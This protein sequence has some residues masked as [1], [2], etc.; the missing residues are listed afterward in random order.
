MNGNVSTPLRG[1]I[2]SLFGPFEAPLALFVVLVGVALGAAINPYCTIFVAIGLPAVLAVCSEKRLKYGLLALAVYTAFEAFLLNFVPGDFYFY[3][4]FGHYACLGACFLV[5]L[6]RRL[7]EGRPLWV[8]TPIDVPMALFL[9]VSLISFLI[10]RQTSIPPIAA[11][12]AFQPFLRFIV[13]VFY[14]LMFIDFDK[15]D[16]LR[17]TKVLLAVVLVEGCVGLAQSFLGPPAWEFLAPKG[18]EFGDIAV[19]GLTQELYGGRYEVFGTLGRYQILGAFMGT[20]IVLGYPFFKSSTL[21]RAWLM[22]VYGVAVSCL[23]LAASRGP[24]L[25]TL[26][27]IWAILCVQRRRAAIV[28]PVAAAAALV[29]IVVVYKS[30]ITFL[31]W[32]EASAFQ[33]LLEVFSPD[34]LRVALDKSGRLY[35][36]SLFFVD[37][38]KHSLRDFMLGFGP[39]SL[40]YTATDVFGIFPLTRL[41]VPQNWQYYVTDV[42]W[43]YIFGQTGILGLGC[44]V[45]ACYRLFKTAY[46]T[47]RTTDDPIVK[48]LMLGCIGVFALF[49]VTGFFT[50]IFELRALSL[51]FWLY[52]GIVVKLAGQETAHRS[53]EGGPP[54]STEATP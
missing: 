9:V 17:F 36:A 34:Y 4:R 5:I 6:V 1:R 29:F 25:G 22:P 35:Y 43:T 18:G 50:P 14:L 15:G 46:K 40:G 37:V 53:K 7:L 30:A 48:D 54:S 16:A 49:A 41:G 42:N 28:L 23:V 13:L 39:G 47:M 24:W 20:F 33:R 12:I 51:Y 31:G 2:V 32:D 38:F 44:I 52:A 19:G 45:W 21:S 10:P 8:R 27:G 3:A 26:A 11:A